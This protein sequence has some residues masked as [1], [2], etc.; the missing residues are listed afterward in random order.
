MSLSSN[1]GQPVNPQT[2]QMNATMQWMMPMMFAYFTFSVPSGLS[3]YWVVTNI[4]GIV[5]NWFV[6]G[7][8]KRPLR[9]LLFS[10]PS[11]QQAGNRR[12]R[13]ALVNGGSPPAGKRPADGK[14][15]DENA[16][17]PGSAVRGG[18]DTSMRTTT[19]PS[20]GRGAAEKRTPNGK[21]GGKRKDSR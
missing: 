19:R 21:G 10:P 7:W 5:M 12:G 13:A 15:A 11:A 16:A 14:A 9:E 6:Y 1:P 8:S 4:I 20:G 3:M 17:R 2:Q 18:R